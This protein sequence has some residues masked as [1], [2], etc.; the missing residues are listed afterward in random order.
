[1]LKDKY[2]K[3]RERRTEIINFETEFLHHMDTNYADTL[4]L[5]ASGKLT[6]KAVE[7]IKK[8]AAEKPAAEEKSAEKAVEKEPAAEKTVTDLNR[9]EKYP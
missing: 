5:L 9:V 6:D 4:K 3:G 2:G 8:A 1:M 7:D